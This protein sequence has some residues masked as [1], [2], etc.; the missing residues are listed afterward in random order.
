MKRIYKVCLIAL[1]FFVVV[2]CENGFDELNTSKTGATSLD[3]LLVL[4]NAVISSSIPAGSLN[5][6]LGIV[7][8]VIS[9]NTGV[10]EGA[11]F[12]KDNSGNTIANWTNYFQNV[13]KYAN[14][15][16]VRTA[17]VPERSN[18][19]NMARIIKANAFMV[20]T[21]TYGNVPYEEGG[22]GYTGQIFFPVYQTQE[23]IYNDII[24]ELTAAAAALNA[25]GKI[26]TG[27]VLYSGNI[28]KWKKFGYSLLLR[29][30]MR[31]SEVNATKAQST[32]AAAYAGGVILSNADNAYIR[33]DA[34][35]INGVGN[36]LNGTEAANF[37]LAEPF[38]NALKDNSDP[39]LTAIAIRFVGATSGPAQV[40]GVSTKDPADQFGLP[41]GS[42]D[43]AADVAG[44]ALPG[45]GSRY[46][47]SQVD[48][49]RMVK[50]T[51]PLFL[52]TSAQNNLLLAEARFRGWITDGA[53]VDYFTA[54]IKDHMDQM[55][56]FDAGSAVP[57]ADR[58]VYAAAMTATFDGN[59]L[60]Q[61]NYEY[62]IASF[63]NGPE[64]WANFR[65]S[66]F[67]VLAVN[68][69]PGRVVDF[70]TRLTYPPS[71]ILVNSENVQAAIAE[72]GPDK[73]DTKVWWDQ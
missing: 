45:G 34:N 35:Y 10:L 26:E 43:G 65:R 57:D 71:E 50:R 30:G 11:N 8:Q 60:E 58:D 49:T 4:N 68:P 19:Y 73:L 28:D 59:E 39:R 21:D 69:F 23:L 70:I 29:A 37:Y 6:E 52:V 40:P 27:D 42:T 24:L 20:L 13:V 72:Q 1:S 64:A 12:N 55:V 54:G 33:H 16:I 38:V 14:D 62:W 18:L 7:Q 67:P 9:P 25:S 63:L 3:P 44:A 56:T 36:T 48:R 66:G 31:L 46:A 5:Y 41:M 17:D 61:I 15:V 51:S 32:V 53:A 22:K 47:F 2:S